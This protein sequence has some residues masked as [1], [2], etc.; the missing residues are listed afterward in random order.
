[1]SHSDTFSPITLIA[2]STIAAIFF[3]CSITLNNAQANFLFKPKIDYDAGKQPQSVA[4]GDLNGDGHPDL[5][6]AN[7][8]INKVSVL[9]GN[10]DGSFQSAMS[11]GVSRYPHSVAIGDLN[12]DGYLDLAVAGGNHPP[13]D[14][15][16]NVSVLLGNGDGTFLSAVNYGAGYDSESVAI[17]DLNGDG[18]LDLAVA[19]QWSDNVSVL[20]GNGDGTFLSADNYG[21]VRMPRS[22]AIDDLNGDGYLDLAV[23][24][25]GSIDNVN[26]S[27]LLGNG[28]GSFKSYVSYGAGYSPRSVAIGDLNGDGDLDLAVANFSD[29]VSV[30]LGNGDGSFQSAVSY[31]H[32]GRF[33]QSIAIGDLNGDGDLDL[34]MANDQSLNVSVLLGNGE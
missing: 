7:P 30:L 22:V 23:A 8:T 1:M 31:S 13:D 18:Y 2:W 10:G 12:G 32:A 27:V 33:P 20:L 11:Y 25:G 26:V 5:A 28:D 21:T 19:N 15:S 14:F 4:I 16:D 9:L 17:G 24:S 29:K 6:V 34:A 3:M